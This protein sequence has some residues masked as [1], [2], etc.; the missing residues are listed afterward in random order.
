MNLR[1][2]KLQAKAIF[3]TKGFLFSVGVAGSNAN[4]AAGPVSVKLVSNDVISIT[5][6]T[7]ASW[8]IDSSCNR[9]FHKTNF[10]NPNLLVAA[11]GLSPSR[12]R[13]GGS[14]NDALVYGLSSGS[15]ECADISPTNDC[16]YVTP[17]CLNAS[18]WDN[19]YKFA[20][21]SGTQFIFGV[22]WGLP[23]ACSEGASYTWNGTNAA[24]LLSYMSSHNQTMWGFELGNEVN[25]NGGVPCNQTAQQQ[26][27]G[28]EKFAEMATAHQPEAMLIGP[29]SGKI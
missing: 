21:S 14:G 19:L 18:H 20:E 22:A 13:F 25:N 8:N 27:A 4:S 12:L 28:M 1:T 2:H 5:E 3:M 17:G 7:Y 29:D 9:G 16:G 10:S 15:P 23:Q 11:K 6:P 26:A 24:T